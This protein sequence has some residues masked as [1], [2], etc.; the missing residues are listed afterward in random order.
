[1]SIEERINLIG[2]ILIKRFNERYNNDE[3]FRLRNNISTL[4]RRSI[5]NGGY[6]KSTKTMSIIGCSFNQ[7][8]EH[9]NNN[10]YGFKYGDDNLD[11]DHI[12]PLCNA[13]SEEELL[14]LNHFKNLQLLP[15]EYNRNIKKAFEWNPT[16]FEIYFM[17]ILKLG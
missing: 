15:S 14:E 16:D 6:R 3:L 8:L 11:I 4:I 5:K 12:V 17:T 10:Q 1:M 13:K 9:L 2:I 7:L